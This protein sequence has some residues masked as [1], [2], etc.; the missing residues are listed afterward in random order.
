MTQN[1][2]FLDCS[3]KVQ[4]INVLIDLPEPPVLQQILDEVRKTAMRVGIRN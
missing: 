3:S 2:I 1:A 4:T